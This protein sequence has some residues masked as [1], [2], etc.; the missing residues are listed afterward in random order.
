MSEVVAAPKKPTH[1]EEIKDA[2]PTLAGTLAA[3]LADPFAGFSRYGRALLTMLG[4]WF[5]LFAVGLPAN[6]V[7]QFATIDVG[8]PNLPLLALGYGLSILT[9]LFVTSRHLPFTVQS[10]MI[11]WPYSA[12]ILGMAMQS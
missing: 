1:N 4:C 6:A 10:T 11:R 9:A 5:A 12:E 7:I 3:T 2:I 8:S